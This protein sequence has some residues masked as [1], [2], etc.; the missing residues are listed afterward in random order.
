VAVIKAAIISVPARVLA[1]PPTNIPVMVGMTA[2]AKAVAEKIPVQMPV[3][4]R[5]NA[6][7]R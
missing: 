5:A 1:T 4:E 6:V 2:K 7:Y 3:K